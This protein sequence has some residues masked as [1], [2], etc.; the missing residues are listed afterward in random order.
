M[1]RRERETM[2]R[3]QASRERVRIEKPGVTMVEP[4][5]YRVAAGLYFFRVH[6]SAREPLTP[7]AFPWWVI[8]S[9]RLGGNRQDAIG[10]LAD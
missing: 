2:E 10:T 7:H 6:G 3:T 4:G 9:R 1:I 5:S 8:P